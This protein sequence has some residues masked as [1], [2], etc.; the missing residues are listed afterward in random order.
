[1]TTEELKMMQPAEEYIRML[2]H[3]RNAGTEDCMLST[4]LA[5][6][7]GL[8]APDMHHYLIDVGVLRRERKTHELK[9]CRPFAGLGLAKTRSHF[10]YNSKGDLTETRF[11]V[12]TRKGQELI[13]DMILGRRRRPT[14]R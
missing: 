4:D 10:R 7:L 5:R 2:Q 11:P 12:W 8:T 9:L 6:E 14:T 1:M 3:K 13:S